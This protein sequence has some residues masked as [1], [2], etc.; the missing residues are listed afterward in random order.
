MPATLAVRAKKEKHGMAYSPEYKAWQGMLDRCCNPNSQ[1][2][3]RYGS[4]GITVCQQWQDSFAAFFADLGPRPGPGYSLDRINNEGNYEPGNCRWAT[5][6]CQ[7]RNT[8]RNIYLEW[9]GRRMILADWARE[10]GINSYTLLGR[11][12]RGLP[13][14]NILFDPVRGQRQK[15][16]RQ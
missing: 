5:N 4:R 2:F 10:T 11:H 6:H 7:I 13:T 15:R 12:K 9:N 16:A 1:R 3:H 14:E 8:A